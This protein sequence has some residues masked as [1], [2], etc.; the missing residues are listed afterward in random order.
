MGEFIMFL[1]IVAL[2]GIT[3]SPILAMA[4]STTLLIIGGNMTT[5]GGC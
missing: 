5:K 4:V 3:V 1:G 2:W